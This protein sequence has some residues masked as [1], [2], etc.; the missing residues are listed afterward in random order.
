M[1]AK[2]VKISCVSGMEESILLKG[3]YY[4][5]KPINSIQFLSKC[6]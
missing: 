5:K 2:N 3:S 6:Q 4:L 1:D